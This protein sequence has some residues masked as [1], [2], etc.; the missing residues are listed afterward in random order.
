MFKKKTAKVWREKD[1]CTIRK[2]RIVFTTIDGEQH[3]RDS[4]WYWEG[5]GIYLTSAFRMIHRRLE[6]SVFLDNNGIY[7]PWHAIL[8]YHVSEKEHREIYCEIVGGHGMGLFE[9]TYRD[10]EIQTDDNGNE[11]LI[12]E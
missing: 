8:S 4:L 12:I 6:D 10:D 5:T 3:E 1:K 11:F 7:Y 2:F 9:Y